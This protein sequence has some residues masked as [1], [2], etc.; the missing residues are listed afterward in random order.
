VI[1]LFMGMLTAAMCALLSL[2]GPDTGWLIYPLL[3]VLGVV[4][5]GWGGIYVTM[6]GE[7]GGKEAA[8]AAYSLATVVMLFGS[9]VG[10]PVFGLIVDTTGSYRTAWQAMAL[11]GVMSVLFIAMIRER[12]H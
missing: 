10:P 4:A 2:I 3:V 9:M 8:G 11:A 5:I 7:L 1:L 12:R 6:A